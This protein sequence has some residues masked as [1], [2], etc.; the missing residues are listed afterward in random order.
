[1]A[2]EAAE[3]FAGPGAGNQT[4]RVKLGRPS[5]YTP[6]TIAKLTQAIRLGAT[7][8]LACHYAGI[9]IETLA[10]WRAKKPGFSE[11]LK[12]AEGAAAFSWLTKIEEASAGGEW[13]AAAWKLERRYPR[14]Y[15]RRVHEVTGEDGVPLTIRVEYADREIGPSEPP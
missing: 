7:Y 4:R 10:Q 2:T 9:S 3:R 8:T 15:G 6:E 12:A 13:T 11:T 1:M 5:K 14:D